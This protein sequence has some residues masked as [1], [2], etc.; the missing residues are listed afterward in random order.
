VPDDPRRHVPAVGAAHHAE[1]IRIHEI[2]PLERLIDHG[3][4]VLVVDGPPTRAALHGALDGPAPRLAVARRAAGV[5]IHHGIPGP[6]IHLELVEELVPVLRERPPVDIQEQRILLALLESD[7]AHD[8]G[9][10]LGAVGRDRGEPLGSTQLAPR[11]EGVSHLGEL[12]AAGEQ[13][14]QRGRRAGGVD[15]RTEDRIQA[16]Q[17]LIAANHQL[18]TPGAIG[19]DAIHVRVAAV[20]GHEEQV[21]P[22]PYRLAK[23]RVGAAVPVQVC[24]QQLRRAASCRDDGHLA[25]TGIVE[26]ARRVQE[27]DPRSIEGPGRPAAQAVGPSEDGRF[28]AAGVHHVHVLGRDDVPV[29]MAARHEGQPIPI[30][31]PRGL[32]VLPLP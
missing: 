30:G 7:R 2:E 27:G 24:G 3:Q 1:A 8:P 25:V 9:L 13:L 14:G 5:R 28:P 23:L 4:H 6:C 12:T 21:V 20:L 10:D 11:G 31:R 18:R 29:L 32:R 16:R 22:V 26:H 17:H 15:D 19:R